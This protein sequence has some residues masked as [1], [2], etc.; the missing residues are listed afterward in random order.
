M[1]SCRRVHAF[2]LSTTCFYTNMT[3]KKYDKCIT[4]SGS[5][6]DGRDIRK[7]SYIFDVDKLIAFISGY[8]KNQSF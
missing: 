1:N 4:Y 3:G 8:L 7:A 5:N 2:Y 6:R